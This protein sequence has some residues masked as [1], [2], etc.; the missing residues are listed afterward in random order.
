MEFSFL[1]FSGNRIIIVT[2]SLS[3][4]TVA[5][6]DT[7]IARLVIAKQRFRGSEYA[8]DGGRIVEK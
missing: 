1:V 5:R 3:V 2:W 8:R 6:E 7:S 4:R